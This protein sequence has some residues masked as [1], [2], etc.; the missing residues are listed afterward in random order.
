[1]P[2]VV[3]F[4]EKNK[5]QNINNLG[6]VTQ[7]TAILAFIKHWFEKSAEEAIGKIF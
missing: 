3:D 2:C 6:E 4:T 7:Q 1:M 5:R